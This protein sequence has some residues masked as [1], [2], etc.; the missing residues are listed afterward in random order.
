MKKKIKRV[1]D[2]LLLS[3][4]LTHE[5]LTDKLNEIIDM[6]NEISKENEKEIRELRQTI[7][8]LIKK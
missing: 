3:Y 8:L 1:D 5:H 7:N 6:V 4:Q 2:V